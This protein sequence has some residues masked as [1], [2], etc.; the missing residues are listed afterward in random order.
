MGYNKNGPTPKPPAPLRSLGITAVANKQIRLTGNSPSYPDASHPFSFIATTNADGNAGFGVT[1]A[2]GPMIPIDILKANCFVEDKGQPGVGVVYAEVIDIPAIKVIPS[3]TLFA[4]PIPFPKASWSTSW[5]Q[6]PV[7]INPHV[8]P[9]SWSMER[10]LN[11]RGAMWTARCN[12]PFGPRPNQ[13]DNIMAMDYFEW[14]PADAQQRMLDKSAN[15]YKHTHAVTGPLIDRDGYHGKYPTQTEVPTQ[16]QFDAYLDGLQRWWDVG[17]APIH[18]CHVDGMTDPSE[19]DALDALYR[20]PRA[21]QLLRIVVYTGWEP[22]KYELTSAQW[23]AWLRR[24]ADVFPNAVRLIHTT[25]D[26]DAPTGGD[27]DKTLVGG[28]A[29]AWRN[30]V[31]YL[32][33]WLIQNGGYLDLDNRNASEVPSAAFV[34]NF[35]AQFDA[36]QGRA[37]IK[38]R[39]VNGVG[40]WPTTSANGGPLRVYAAEWAS[41]RDFWNNWSEEQARLLGDKALA[42]GADGVLDG[43][44]P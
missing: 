17:I 28:N 15:V 2:D 12:V 43:F 41:Y 27:D 39:F 10:L 19:M 33:G 29:T 21:Q 6:L 37:S 1:G 30:A 18:F 4:I 44:H 3:P 8:D 36:S 16:Q 11:I 32:H 20:Q 38:A 23:V 5:V 25:A 34:R 35:T 22:W 42:A 40:G 9:A 7:V 31:P 14:M 26:T 24:G 13:D